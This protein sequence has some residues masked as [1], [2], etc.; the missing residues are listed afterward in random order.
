M[1]LFHISQSQN[2]DY[3]TYDSAVVAAESED[4]ARNITPGDPFDSVERC[5]D[6]CSTPEFVTVRYI[7][8]A[9]DGIK[10]GIVL[11]SFNSG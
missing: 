8:E 4:E 1:K 2:H 10:S 5:W 7:G 6:W 9:A 3:D 11:A